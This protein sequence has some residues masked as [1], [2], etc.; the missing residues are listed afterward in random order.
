MKLK[1]QILAD[2]IN[3]PNN[4]KHQE[5]IYLKYRYLVT[6]ETFKEI[7]EE[8]GLVTLKWNWS[9][10]ENE[11]LKEYQSNPDEMAL[12]FSEAGFKRTANAIS[13]RASKVRRGEIVLGG[14]SADRLTET[15]PT[16]TIDKNHQCE[17]ISVSQ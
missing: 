1:Q 2:L 15:Q 17:V 14:K 5:S 7:V 13:H 6:R 16:E 10:R 8:S 9:H 12:R 11:L 3:D 4:L